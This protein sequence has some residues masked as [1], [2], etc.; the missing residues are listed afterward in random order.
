MWEANLARVG[1]VVASPSALLLGEVLAKVVGELNAATVG[2]LAERDHAVEIVQA[3]GG[4]ADHGGG[5]GHVGAWAGREK[6]GEKEHEGSAVNPIE[7]APR[8]E[9]RGTSVEEE[10]VR[11]QPVSTS[12]ARLLV[13]ALDGLGDGVVNHEATKVFRRRIRTERRKRNRGVSTAR[14]AC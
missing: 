11:G 7:S 6:D 8:W 2:G 1:A 9:R 13:V 10:A 5:A 3:R 12:S 14:R 4:G